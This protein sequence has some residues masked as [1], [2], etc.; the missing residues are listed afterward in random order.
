M[1]RMGLYFFY[2]EKGIA[3]RY[4]DYFL[5]DL[6]ENVQR[7]V[8]VS[9]GPITP[10]ARDLFSQYT[11]EILV[12][13][14]EGFDV[15][16]YKEGLEYIGWDALAEWDELVLT[17]C[18]IMGP[19]YP[20]SGM[21]EAMAAKKADFWGITKRGETLET[22]PDGSVE[23]RIPEHIQSHF[24]V[25]RK[26]FMQ[27]ADLRTYWEEMPEISVCDEAFGQHESLFTKHFADKGYRW[28]VYA[29]TTEDEHFHEYLLLMDPV[30]MLEKYRCPVVKRRSFF[31][32]RNYFLQSSGGEPSVRLMTYLRDYTD[33]DTDMIWENILRTC[34]Q[35][36][37]LEALS[38]IY[39]LPANGLIHGKEA[40]V[41]PLR[42]ALCMHL[43]FLDLLDES[44]YYASQAPAE[45]DI[46][47][48]T[49]DADRG[50]AMRKAF[51]ALPNRVEVRVIENRGRAIASLLVGLADVNA[52][53]DVVCFYHD[54]K[55]TEILPHSMGRGF[56]YKVN[57]N[58][59]PSEDFVRN[60]LTLFEQN[61]RL[62]ML[63]PTEPNH[64]TYYMVLGGEW[65]L[66]FENT[67]A[68]AEKM[69]LGVP[70]APDKYPIAPLGTVFWYRTRALQKMYDWGWSYADFP[71][72]PCE[73][74]G[75]ILHAI[76][77]VK[78]FVVQSA[79]YYPAYLISDSYASIELTNLRRYL[80]N[81]FDVLRERGSYGTNQNMIQMD[82]YRYAWLFHR[83]ESLEEE[84]ERKNSVKYLLRLRLKSFLPRSVYGGMIRTKRFLFGPRGVPYSYDD[85]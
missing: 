21:F 74:D 44:V 12:R 27:S 20:F 42:M 77:R 40:P 29:D 65:A 18:T 22:M 78:P 72:E 69:Q 51:N 81:F 2:D 70:M 54:K 13:K 37:I 5:R 58:T 15:W 53:Y 64:G 57:E 80:R 41:Q 26:D 39:T 17:N 83:I 59:L 9:N 1:K 16:G 71:E 62:G 52:R 82:E 68:L 7:L 50:D 43:Y 79:G 23:V 75:T 55:A 28:A 60:V 49:T 84:M 31:Q 35:S 47:I 38:L 3:D 11:G 66:N 32:S 67:E 4:V 56:A 30:L 73:I 33:Y 10:E 34:H 63:S 76:E 8:V 46:Y 48:T 6:S 61:P 24:M 36:D 19:V 85:E 45:V 25:Y 14:N